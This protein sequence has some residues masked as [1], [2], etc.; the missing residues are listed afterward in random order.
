MVKFLINRPIA[1]SVTII[2]LLV[3]GLLTLLRI[4][5]SLMPE[6]DIPVVTVQ[7]SYPNAPARE[8][9]NSVVRPV[10]R[11]LLQVA[12]LE[13]IESETRDGQA[14]IRL[15]FTHGTDIHLSYIE[16]NEKI[17]DVMSQMPRD[18]RRPRVVKASAGDIPVF[19]IMVTRRA[20]WEDES[21][22]LE[23]SGFVRSVIVK[24]IE[25][26]P[27]VA[28]VDLSGFSTP[29]IMIRPD[30]R[31]MEGLGISQDDLL[32]AIQKNNLS[33]GSLMVREGYYQYH[34][35]FTQYLKNLDDI[36][37]IYI[38][39][40][41]R[42]MQLKD[43][44][45]VTLR[46][47]DRRGMFM[48]RDKPGI[49]LSVIKQSDA[50]MEDLKGELD[51][52]MLFFSD[53]YSDLDFEI[54]KDQ[55]RILTYSI[56][57]LR[58]SL[59]MGAMLAILVM[60][61]FLRDFR[62]PLLIAFTIPVSL[63]ICFLFFFLFG[64]SINIISLSG[65]ILAVG[66]MTD[67]SI[68]VIDNINQYRQRG[69][70]LGESCVRGTNEIIRPLIS[71]A[72]TTCA[73]FI[74]LIF[75]SGIA[76]ALF[77]DQAVAVS[78][79]LFVSFM[80]SV[81]L[82]PML[83]RLFYLNRPEAGD[84]GWL[85]RL[86]RLNYE[87]LYDRSFD[88][89]FKWKGL[90]VTLFLLLMA[91]GFLMLS[92]IGISG[93]PKMQQT[94]TVGEIEWN[95][96]IHAR[97]NADRMK[98]LMAMIPDSILQYSMLV[99][100]PQF[101]LNRSNERS[102]SESEFYVRTSS[103][104]E[105]ERIIGFL[106]Q[107]FESRYPW[108]SVNFHPPQNIFEAIF[109][110]DAP[111]LQIRLSM[112]GSEEHPSPERVAGFTDSLGMALALDFVQIP[113]QEQLLVEIDP[114]RLLLYR[115]DYEQVVNKLRTALNQRSMG[116]LRS[117]QQITPILLG[118]EPRSVIDIIQHQS[119]T[120]AGGEEVPL[121][122]LVRVGRQQDYK[123]IRAGRRG[124]FAPIELRES[125]LK[126]P[127]I[128]SGVER[129]V[130]MHPD[131]SAEIVGSWFT[132]REL[133]RGLAFVLLISVL[134]LYFILAAQFES[135][136]QPLIVLSELPIDMA[137]ALLMLLLFGE[138]LNIMSAI[139]IIVMSGIIIN[140]SILKIDTI[141]RSRREGTPLLEAIHT[142][143]RR[144]LK[145]IIMTSLTTILALVPILFM[146]GLGAELQRPLALAV[147]GGMVVGTLVSLYFIPLAYWMIYRKTK[148]AAG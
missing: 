112:A 113:L 14:L 103:P 132:Q 137:G 98:M 24:R 47:E 58:Q 39:S 69:L 59:A 79:G 118:D 10:R 129:E 85:K 54:E 16:C 3:L 109:S 105:L 111:E 37:N 93:F 41:D 29:Q 114:E 121:R 99:G 13:D 56:S 72:L 78:V 143:G 106:K 2:A 92:R 148:P 97:E 71:S 138:T 142:G 42:L 120:S 64:I 115:V 60:F 139:G 40:P 48:N 5:V 53:T 117:Y 144:R 33:V 73:V 34:I 32:S 44:A 104:E 49:C 11:Q 90:Y 9:E 123:S 124:E 128:T 4:P 101:L 91:A 81:T 67:N 75:L 25:Q 35:N 125:T 134:L 100:E 46:E 1:V 7:I 94:E 17:D 65:L 96:P 66:M 95:E 50:R 119:V 19:N 36:G 107:E 57:N 133:M 76:G 80:V 141:N 116:T 8:L 130:R 83:Y 70:E 84:S 140:D 77:F 23:L 147:I 18:L 136:V 110:D 12:H 146:S 86:N 127:E 122:S 22:F 30:F 55:T 31:K 135:F 61:F 63:V 28:M 6:I 21:R 45:S 126:V 52:L 51:K 145:P 82:L 88:H 68:I 15:T 102:A 27:E 87:R 20:D 131:L 74:P 26:L 43:L 38:G 89:V 62:S 108:A